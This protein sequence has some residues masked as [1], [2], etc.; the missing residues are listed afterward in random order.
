MCR[1]AARPAASGAHALVRPE[2]DARVTGVLVRSLGPIA[3]VIVKRASAQVQT[4][5]QLVAA[6]LKLCSDA[7]DPLALEAEI[8]RV[9]NQA[10]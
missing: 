4:R 2:D 1:D 9:L 8:W 6:V 10:D 7:P 3:K 5:G